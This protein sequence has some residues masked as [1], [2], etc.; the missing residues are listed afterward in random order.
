MQ[1]ATSQCNMNHPTGRQDRCHTTRNMQHA[2]LN[3]TLFA[4]HATSNV[5]VPCAAND[6]TSIIHH[7]TYNAPHATPCKTH[8]CQQ[9]GS[10]T[11]VERAMLPPLNA[12]DPPPILTTPPSCAPP[13]R[14]AYGP[15]GPPHATRTDAAEVLEIATDSNVALPTS[16][17]STPPDACTRAQDAPSLRDDDSIPHARCN[18]QRSQCNKV[19]ATEATC[20]GTHAAC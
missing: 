6:A 14:S 13:H 7:A 3:A 12:T 8:N 18:V 20:N 19:D 5:R 9:R 15:I 4:R 11:A 17:N 16:M 2:T 10:R 1:R